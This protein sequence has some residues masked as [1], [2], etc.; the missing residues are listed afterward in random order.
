[1]TATS[2]EARF[3]SAYGEHRAGEGRGIAGDAL[4]ELP[5]V[6]HGPV[7]RQWA[8]RARSYEVFM[9]K[10]LAPLA[11]HSRSAL[12]VADL[13]AGN[14]WLSWRVAR[15]GHAAVALDIRD[16]TVD[17]LGAGTPYVQN[18]A[19]RMQRCVG[20]F[21]HLPLADDSCNLVVFDASLHYATDLRSALREALR[22]LATGGRIAII[23]SPFYERAHDGEAMVEEKRRTASEKF[24]S[25]ADALMELPFVEYLTEE[26]LAA[27]GGIRWTRHRVR[28]PLWYELRPVMARLRRNRIPSRFDVW[29]GVPA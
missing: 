22:I 9:R 13:G 23:D 14:G 29:E 27:E 18:V 4:F 3:R 2:A 20:S 7:A 21:E 17:G 16:D 1:M 5:Y 8:V 19:D 10:V 24:G 6:H 12:R 28:Y 26:R 25:R 15:L 11:L